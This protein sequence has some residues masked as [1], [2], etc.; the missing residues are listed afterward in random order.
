MFLR[1]YTSTQ[2]RTPR[3]YSLTTF[4]RKGT[5]TPESVGSPGHRS[6]ITGSAIFSGSRRGSWVKCIRARD[7][8]DRSY[9]SNKSSGYLCFWALND[10]VASQKVV[11][12]ISATRTDTNSIIS[13]VRTHKYSII[14]GRKISMV[15]HVNMHAY[16]AD[17][18]CILT[19]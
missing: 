2:K 10:R 1:C 16:S 11:A 14:S 6:V 15:F 3:K 17:W 12:I 7:V 18:A 8:P 4:E 19:L 9:S 5:V 13:A